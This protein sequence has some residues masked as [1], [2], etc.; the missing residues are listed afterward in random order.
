MVPFGVR[1]ISLIV[2]RAPL[3]DSTHSVMDGVDEDTYSNN[4]HVDI[5]A[6]PTLSS[7]RSA[8]IT[9]GYHSQTCMSNIKDIRDTTNVLSVHERSTVTVQYLKLR[10]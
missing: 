7:M 9:K 6:S 3:V 5:A 1:S 2:D 8:S 4:N 10:L